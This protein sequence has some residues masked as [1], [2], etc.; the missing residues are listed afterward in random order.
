[1]K[2]LLLVLLLFGC[3]SLSA[4]PLVGIISSGQQNNAIVYPAQNRF[5][6]SEDLTN[7]WWTKEGAPSILVNQALDLDGNN[8]MNLVTLTA[9]TAIYRMMALSAST[10]YYFSFDVKRGTATDLFYSVYISSPAGNIINPTSYYSL[11][12]SSEVRRMTFAITLPA[13]TYNTAISIDATGGGGVAGTVYL[14]RM[15]LSTTPAPYVKT[16]TTAVIP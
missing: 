6:W 9:T 13:G 14:G 2:H 7:A 4:Q 16:T 15:Q 10:T 11:T 5:L 8:T 3:I 1:M 12:S